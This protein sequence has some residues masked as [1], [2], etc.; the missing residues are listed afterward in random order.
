[1]WLKKHAMQ[2]RVPFNNELVPKK[3][4]N[5]RQEISMLSKQS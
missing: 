5:R 2:R 3:E 1:M 4:R